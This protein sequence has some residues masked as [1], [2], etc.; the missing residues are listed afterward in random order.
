VARKSLKSLKNQRLAVAY[1]RV[2]TEEQHLGPEA[3]RKQIELWA[4]HQEITVVAWHLDQGLSGAAGIEHR[5]GLAK[6]INDVKAHGAGWLVIAKR[7]RLARDAHLA[8]TIE[9]VVK[10]LGARIVSATGGP[11]SDEPIARFGRLVEDGVAELERDFTV[12]RTKAALAVKR[13]RGERI[14]TI[15]YGSR[16]AGNGR[17]H[18]PRR[19]ADGCLGCLCLEECPDEQKTIAA[20]HELRAR[21][22]TL[23]GIASMLDLEGFKTRRGTPFTHV[24]V[25]KMLGI[26][27]TKTPAVPSPEQTSP[28]EELEEAPEAP[29]APTEALEDQQ[30]RVLGAL[31]R[32]GRGAA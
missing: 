18:E 16:L 10:A 22:V 24:Q 9:R 30:S 12:A 27:P 26:A 7:D 5:L 31:A 29:E 19:C 11:V 20:A 32:L 4:K 3:Q 2:S 15:P 14:G 21:G 6:A 1:M 17:H 25:C 13:D 23:R 8:G 28:V